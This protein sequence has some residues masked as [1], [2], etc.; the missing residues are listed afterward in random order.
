MESEDEA[1]AGCWA[2]RMVAK[3]LGQLLFEPVRLHGYGKWNRDADGK[4][5]V[6]EFI[7]ESFEPLSDEPLS[8]ALQRLRSIGAFEGVT[9]DE[10]EALRHDQQE[11]PNGGA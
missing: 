1:V 9:V 7:I 6:Q 11:S 4:W 10:L 2:D 5:S 3:R 8:E